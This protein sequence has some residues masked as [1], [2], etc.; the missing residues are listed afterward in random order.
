M[1][2]KPRQPPLFTLMLM[3]SMVT[4][5]SFGSAPTYA[6]DKTPGCDC[7]KC[8]CVN[9]NCSPVSTLKAD[10][11]RTEDRLNTIEKRLDLLEDQLI[12][13]VR[14]GHTGLFRYAADHYDGKSPPKKP[15]PFP[16]VDAKYRLGLAPLAPAAV[17]PVNKGFCVGKGC[18]ACSNAKGGAYQSPLR[19]RVRRLH[20]FGN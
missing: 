13:A 2:D 5:S 14:V 16:P 20:L 8:D 18:A 9:C 1:L 12:G 17:Q 7:V 10:P 4:M 19:K 15:E 3:F 6:G 11:L